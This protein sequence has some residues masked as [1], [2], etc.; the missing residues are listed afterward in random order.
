MSYRSGGTGQDVHS[1][2]KVT[3]ACGEV[4]TLDRTGQVEPCVTTIMASDQ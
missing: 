3:M 1:R 2:H 4:F